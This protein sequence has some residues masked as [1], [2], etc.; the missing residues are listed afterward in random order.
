MKAMYVSLVAMTIALAACSGSEK[1]QLGDDRSQ[2]G[3]LPV[4]AHSV[5]VDGQE[6][7]VWTMSPSISSRRIVAMDIIL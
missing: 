3:D 2:L 6:M 4:V 5:E 7:I 1:S